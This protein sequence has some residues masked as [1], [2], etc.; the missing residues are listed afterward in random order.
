MLRKKTLNANLHAFGVL[1]DQGIH[2]SCAGCPAG[3]PDMLT[4]YP[5]YEIGIPVSCSNCPNNWPGALNLLG[6]GGDPSW[7]AGNLGGNNF[8]GFQP[9]NNFAPDNKFDSYGEEDNGGQ[10]TQFFI[11][12]TTSTGAVATSTEMQTAS[13]GDVAATVDGATSE[14]ATEDKEENSDGAEEEQSSHE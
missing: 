5:E 3:W 14:P 13:G 10:S 4:V 1:T 7:V 12:F 9:G 11:K 6:V 2:I 8:F